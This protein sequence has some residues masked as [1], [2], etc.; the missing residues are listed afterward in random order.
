MNNFV[1]GMLPI[2]LGGGFL[3]TAV[4]ASTLNNDDVDFVK[5]PIRMPAAWSVII[6]KPIMSL[7][8]WRFQK[9]GPSKREGM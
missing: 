9:D 3:L 8:A 7:P 5:L 6:Q 4:A 2:L 1:G